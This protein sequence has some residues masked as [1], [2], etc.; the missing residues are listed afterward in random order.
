M[1][2]PFKRE[3]DVISSETLETTHKKIE[4]R[5]DQIERELAVV[6]EQQRVLSAGIKR[7]REGIKR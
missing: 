6:R 5:L 7:V 2:W 1:R 4:H 3:P